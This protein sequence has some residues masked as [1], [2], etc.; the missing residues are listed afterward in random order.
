LLSDSKSKSIF[1]Y[2]RMIFRLKNADLSTLGL[3]ADEPMQLP[4]L[5]ESKEAEGSADPEAVS[6]THDRQDEDRVKSRSEEGNTS[7]PGCQN[8][9]LPEI[10]APSIISAVDSKPLDS[11]HEITEVEAPGAEED[12]KKDIDELM[13]EVVVYFSIT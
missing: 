2:I 4:A 3:A 8:D 11:L 12:N 1:Q 5:D 9:L 7:M 6:L 13:Q 10:P